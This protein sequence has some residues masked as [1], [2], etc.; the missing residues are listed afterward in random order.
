MNKF[1][2]IIP[3]IRLPRK[4]SEF[5]YEV[6]PDLADNL[7]LGQIVKINF[8]NTIINGAIYR[9]SHVSNDKDRSY[10]KIIRAVNGLFIN[11][12][13]IKL[14]EQFSEYFFVSKSTVLN[15]ILNSLPSRYQSD[16]ISASNNCQ[17]NNKQGRDLLV[18]YDDKK[19][20]Y[21][22][23]ID[24][25]IKK[26]LLIITPEISKVKLYES[27]LAKYNPIVFHRQLT[28]NKF[29]KNYTDLFSQK[30]NLVI[31]TRTALF[32]PFSKLDCLIID[33]EDNPNHRQSEQNP[34][35]HTE[36][37]A[38]ILKN[39]TG[40]RIIY[41]STVPRLTTYYKCVNKQIDQLRLNLKTPIH[42]PILIDLK[43]DR[44]I[45][46]YLSISEKLQSILANNIKEGK[47]TILFLNKTGLSK[48]LV[49]SDCGYVHRCPRCHNNLTIHKKGKKDNVLTCHICNY[50]VDEPLNCQKCKGQRF[51]NSGWGL[52]KSFRELSLLFPKANI[53]IIDRSDQINKNIDIALSTNKL[54]SDEVIKKFDTTALLSADVLLNLP[55]FTAGE[56]TFRHLHELIRISNFRKKQVLIQTFHP[57]NPAVKY[58]LNLDL[59][60][61]YKQELMERKDYAYPPQNELV[62]LI[63]KNKNKNKI[64]KRSAELFAEINKK[65]IPSGVEII[66]PGPTFVEKIRGQYRWQLIIKYNP[67]HFN[68]V[69]SLIQLTGDDWLIDINPNNLLTA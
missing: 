13:Q 65:I 37:V 63:I 15:I 24:N 51:K 26:N 48:N 20:K 38:N 46:N 19:I 29:W 67:S 45:G 54:I 34:R 11:S 64:I 66:Q 50:T 22:Y 30:S 69:K 41:F 60:N 33:D 52:E 6:P 32:M 17:K 49:C 10:K 16:N 28:R 7:K 27:L 56:A 14:L 21:D 58:S 53:S 8:R 9:L 36:Q 35:F 31:G 43:K 59:D 5:D 44:K 12:L 68:F 4:L 62:R 39:I 61:F 3:A 55:D 18:H 1:A 25:L 23:I 40:C 2:A 47:K 57:D 42:K